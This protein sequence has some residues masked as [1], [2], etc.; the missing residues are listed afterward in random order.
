METT[1]TKLKLHIEAIENLTAERKAVQE[2]IS[3]RYKLAASEGYDKKAIREIIKLRKLRDDERRE[4]EAVL[5]TYK[6]NLGID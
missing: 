5:E 1:D 6:C 2:D 4:Q 3:E